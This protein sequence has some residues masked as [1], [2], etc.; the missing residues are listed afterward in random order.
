MASEDQMALAR[1]HEIV[2]DG[3]LH[4]DEVVEQMKSKIH[5]QKDSQKRQTSELKGVY[6]LVNSTAH[7]NRNQT[8]S[9]AEAFRGL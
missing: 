4:I 5:L 2:R 6:S 7:K 9:A 8:G 1:L 3:N